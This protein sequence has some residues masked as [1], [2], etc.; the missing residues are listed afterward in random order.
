MSWKKSTRIS[1]KG[2]SFVYNLF[3][4]L[5][6]F[7]LLLTLLGMLLDWSMPLDG[8]PFFP[9]GIAMRRV[10]FFLVGCIFLSTWIPLSSPFDLFILTFSL[11]DMKIHGSSLFP[12]SLSFFMIKISLAVSASSFILFPLDDCHVAI[13]IWISNRS[14]MHCL[15]S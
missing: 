2:S 1:I 3:I 10:I 14:E 6:F 5:L 13:S 12:S 9:I 7:I 11:M 15:T 8:F 4:F